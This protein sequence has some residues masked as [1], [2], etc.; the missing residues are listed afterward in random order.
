MID[1]LDISVRSFLLSLRS[2]PQR[3]SVVIGC[4]SKSLGVRW[5][6]K[7]RNLSNYFPVTVDLLRALTHLVYYVTP[8]P[9]PP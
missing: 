5:S 8:P 9:S 3:W 7:I 6:V 1:N 4:V 2:F